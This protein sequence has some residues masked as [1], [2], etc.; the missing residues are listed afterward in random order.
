MVYPF[1]VHDIYGSPAIC[2]NLNRLICADVDNEHRLW[3]FNA[4]DIDVLAEPV[5]T[6]SRVIQGTMEGYLYSFNLEGPHDARIAWKF[7]AGWRGQHRR[8]SGGPNSLLRI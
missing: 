5:M 8:G 4:G 2:Q 7:C 3:D 1:G 6:E